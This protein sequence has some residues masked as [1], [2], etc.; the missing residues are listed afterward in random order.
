MFF[1]ETKMSEK[2]HRWKEGRK[3]YDDGATFVVRKQIRV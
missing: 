1:I 3:R 2:A